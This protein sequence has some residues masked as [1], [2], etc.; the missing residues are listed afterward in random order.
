MR[1]PLERGDHGF[2]I[3]IW[4]HASVGKGIEMTFGRSQWDWRGIRVLFNNVGLV[5][6]LMEIGDGSK[7]PLAEPE[8][9]REFS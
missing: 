1:Y 9:F 4:A 6:A 5:S 8:P 7:V 3:R 2:G